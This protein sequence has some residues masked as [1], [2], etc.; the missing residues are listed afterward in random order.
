MFG[1]KWM[2]SVEGIKRHSE[3]RRIMNGNFASLSYFW[4][5]MYAPSSG[6]K[7]ETTRQVSVLHYDTFDLGKHC[8]QYHQKSLI[9][10]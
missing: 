2:L 9:K 3:L 6:S 4:K 1:S 5:L 8:K 10:S 7:T